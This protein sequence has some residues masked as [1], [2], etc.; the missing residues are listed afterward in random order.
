[1]RPRLS[2]LLAPVLFL[3]VSLSLV[4]CAD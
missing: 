1:M 2:S 3:V 4:A